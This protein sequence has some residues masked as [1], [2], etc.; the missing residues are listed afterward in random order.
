MSVS[1]AM[2]GQF[3]ALKLGRMLDTLEVRLDQARQ[4]QLGYLEFLQLIFQDEIERRRSQGLKLRLLRASFE[5]P[6]TLEEFDFAARPQLNP[7]AIRDLACGTFI[8]KK[9]HVL[10]YGPA[11]TG[12]THLAQAL[13]HHACRTGRSVLF[14]KAARLF[15]DLHTARADNSWDQELRRFLASDL[16]IIDDFGL[17]PMVMTQAEDF[18]EIVAERHLRGSI[19]V[20]SNRSPADWLPLFPDPVMANSALDRLAHKAHHIVM[21]GESYRAKTRPQSPLPFSIFNG[22]TEE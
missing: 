15:R 19:V 18:Y 5:E 13:G 21:K 3:K 12:K 14:V 17:K 8:D 16:L 10:L 6:K 20:T 9:E 1:T 11:G 4:G 22:T 2:V 7:A